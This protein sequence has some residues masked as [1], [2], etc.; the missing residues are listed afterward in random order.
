MKNE[1]QNT[2]LKIFA[3]VDA[4]DFGYP[5]LHTKVDDFVV[6]GDFQASLSH[7]GVGNWRPIGIIFFDVVFPFTILVQ[8]FTMSIYRLLRLYFFV[9]LLIH[10]TILAFLLFL[11]LDLRYLLLFTGLYNGLSSFFNNL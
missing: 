5:I 4:F 8:N 7:V 1:S 3:F 6:R 2:Y 10:S 9:L 11:I